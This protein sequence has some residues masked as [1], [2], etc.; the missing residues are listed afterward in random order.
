[1]STTSTQ[2]APAVAEKKNSKFSSQFAS[3]V[4][5]ICLITGFLIYTYVLGNPA[6]FE[7]GDPANHPV[8][9]GIG[10]VFGL[11][12]KGGYIVPVLL[13]FVMI[14]IVFSIERYITLSKA[15][16]KGSVQGL[17]S[18]VRKHLKAGDVK[19]A[20]EACD[21][22]KG[23]V[24]NV[25]KSGLVRYEEMASAANADLTEEQKVV[26]I[27]KEIE[28]A[29]TLELPMLERNLV[30]LATLASVSTLVALLGT[31]LGMIK[32]FSALATAG[33]PDSTALATGISEALINTALG[34]GN[35]A[36]SIIMYNVFTTRVDKMT[37][38]IDEGGYSIVKSFE[39]R[40][41]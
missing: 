33:S 23:S 37:Y 34:I 17:I 22:Q 7:G 30:I 15:S 31:V 14:N 11:M 41:K 6:N 24:G 26:A 10:K 12:H 3:F 8:S 38:A 35:S 36:I 28:E 25:I 4:I 1:M 13:S 32:A 18:N 21:K 40:H 19:A 5:P 29:T 2:T 9:E 16:G 27:Q 20:Q 39:S